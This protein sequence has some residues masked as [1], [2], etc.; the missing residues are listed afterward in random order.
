DTF[1]NAF[2]KVHKPDRR[3]REVKEKADKVDEEVNHVEKSVARV[4]RG[5]SDGETVYNELATQVGKLVP[6]EPDVEV[7]QQVSAATVDELGRAIKYPKDHTDENY[8]GSLR[9]MEAYI[10]SV[11]ALLKSREQKQ[12]DF[13]ALVDYRNKATAERESLESNPSS[14]YAS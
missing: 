11:K 13:A 6:V 8:L 12:L 2:T 9:D 10:L 14:Y 4:A 5:Q 7:P 3:F 1:V